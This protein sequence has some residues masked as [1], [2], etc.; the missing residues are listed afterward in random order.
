MNSYFDVVVAG[1]G[2][3]GAAVSRCL[4]LRGLSVALV[5]RSAFDKPRVGESLA[6]AV[7]P[8]LKD[9][10]VWEPFRSLNPLPS[11]GTRSSWG[12]DEPQS[13]SHLMTPHLNG[14]HVDRLAFDRMLAD[15]AVHAGAQMWTRSRLVNIARVEGGFTVDVLCSGVQRTIETRFIIDAT[16][17][18]A[19]VGRRLGATPLPFDKLI[20]VAVPFADA[21]A[22]QHCYTLVET[23]AEGW[24]YAAPVVQG[25]SVA[26]L[27]TDG[28]LISDQRTRTEDGWRLAVERTRH[29]LQRVQECTPL[30][31]PCA[32]T[33]VSHRLLRQPGDH[34]PWLALGDAAL[35]VD[36]IS[37]SGM[38][39]ALRTARQAAETAVEVL[40]GNAAAIDRYE[41][42]RNDECTAYL[43]E[44]ASYYAMEQRWQHT[45]F[46]SRRLI[47]LV[48]DRL[49][50]P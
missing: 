21:N 20:G 25:R 39:R 23:S 27:M 13:Y 32:Y 38:V 48:P 34:S 40:S 35:A 4:A 43:E 37:G 1:A 29:M 33:A 50:S 44:R 31:S 9:L 11:Y 41:S 22:E 16:G 49:T 5:E 46:W 3:A 18:S 42:N 26:M 15:S 14:W 12:S 28:D 2:P 36:P 30:S 47:H 19:S 24:W 6:P 10:G 8:L 7:T 45:P 17:R